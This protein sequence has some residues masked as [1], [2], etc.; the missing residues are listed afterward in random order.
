CR[1][2][3]L[4]RSWKRVLESA[5]YLGTPSKNPHRERCRLRVEVLE[6]RTLLSTWI[7]KGPAPILGGQDPGGDPVSGRIAAIAAHPTDPNTIYI[8]AA[9]GGVWK[10]TD[11]GTSWIPLTDS[12]HTLFMGAIALAPSDPNII[13]AG[14]GEATNSSLSFYGRG[15]LKSTDGGA[16]W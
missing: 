3:G 7:P 13:Y 11:G 2:L 4:V 9:G 14:T 12:Q 1:S 16:T 10:T 5:R 8:A 6:D 15:V